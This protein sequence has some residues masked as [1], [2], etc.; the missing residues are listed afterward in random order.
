MVPPQQNSV[1]A[2]VLSGGRPEPQ[3]G[4][5]PE[6]RPVPSEIFIPPKYRQGCLGRLAS[7]DFFEKKYNFDDIDDDN[8][9]DDK[10]N[11]DEGNYNDND[12]SDVWQIGGDID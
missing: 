4:T 5:P 11:D 3:Q 7:R 1:Q 2:V 8:G 9:N 12:D 10:G 6:P